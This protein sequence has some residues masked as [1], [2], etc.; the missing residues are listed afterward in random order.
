K[1]CGEFL[2][3][4][5]RAIED[6]DACA[7]LAKALDDRAPEARGAA[8]YQRNF[9]FQPSHSCHLLLE[10]DKNFAALDAYRVGS[11][12]NRS[13]RC[14]DPAGA[15]AK[16]RLV[17]RADHFVAL[18]IALGQ[19]E[20]R[21]GAGVIGG[22]KFLADTEHREWIFAFD[23]QGRSVRDL[24]GTADFFPG[25][26]ALPKRRNSSYAPSGAPDRGLWYGPRA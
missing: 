22:E 21:M 17:Q 2:A 14:E 18:D 12:R 7:F 4:F 5:A 16:A 26:R 20:F 10:L 3:A 1:A 25:H 8:G 13:G 24:I 6:H 19:R 23:L 11:Q 15:Q 9:S